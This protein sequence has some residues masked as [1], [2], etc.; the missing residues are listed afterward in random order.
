M[1]SKKSGQ[2]YAGFWI[3]SAAMILDGLFLATPTLGLEYFAKWSLTTYFGIDQDVNTAPNNAFFTTVS[4]QLWVTI[5]YFGFLQTHLEGTLGKK[6]FGLRVVSLSNHPA[7]LPQ[8]L[9]RTLMLIP[10]SFLFMAGHLA[11]GFHT[12]KQGWHDQVAGTAVISQQKSRLTQK[13]KPQAHSR[14]QRRA[15]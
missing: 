8:M 2:I 13:S 5:L 14:P 1:I 10:S 15:A 11:I 7:T 12:K 4:V 9:L 3:R 6:V